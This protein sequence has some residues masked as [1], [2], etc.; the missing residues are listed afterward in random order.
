MRCKESMDSTTTARPK[1]L[2]VSSKKDLRLERRCRIRSVE[3]RDVAGQ[4]VQ[5]VDRLPS[6]DEYDT[7]NARAQTL[8]QPKPMAGSVSGGGLGQHFAHE[9]LQPTSAIPMKEPL[10]TLSTELTILSMRGKSVVLDSDLARLY[11][12]PTA[13]F[14]QAIKRNRH[15]FPSDFSF[16]LNRDEFKALISQTVT[17][18][19]RGG[20]RKL[21]RVFTEHGAIMAATILNSPRAVAMSVYVVRAFVRMR[22]AL[23][24]RTE[25][26]ER[27]AEIERTLVGHDAALK[28]LYQKIK[29]LLLPPPEPAPARNRVPCRG[30]TPCTELWA[31]ARFWPIHAPAL[32]GEAPTV[33]ECPAVP[34]SD[35]RPRRRDSRRPGRPYDRPLASG[36]RQA[37]LR[38]SG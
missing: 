29:P 27:L 23:L 13:A 15:R 5:H 12:V 22:E 26:E 32:P 16:V 28:D 1:A 25:M 36:Q 2:R 4:N 33:R 31:Q 14:N 24:G 10:Q 20:R 3:E 11:D 19:G 17:S 30:L 35:R 18:K 6:G 34:A 38:W 37:I 8:R 9:A 21:P 7:V